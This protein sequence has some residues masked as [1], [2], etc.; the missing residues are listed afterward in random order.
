[1]SSIQ[2]G[3][4]APHVKLFDTDRNAVTFP[5]HGEV[6]VLAFF[7]AAFTAVCTAE[8]CSFRDS[9]ADYARLDAKVYGISVDSPFALAEFKKQ[10]NINFA[11]LSDH[12]HEAIK[13]YDVV[14]PNLAN[15]GFTAAKRSVFV[16]GKD[17]HVAWQWISENPGQQPAYDDVKNAVTAAAAK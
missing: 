7:P 5:Q 14:F 6:I 4:H 17:G 10:N 15:V 9:L 8:L 11:L 3:M 1:M 12:Q 13:A 16:V 2:V